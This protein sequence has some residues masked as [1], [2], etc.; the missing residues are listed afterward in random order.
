MEE[1]LILIVLT[2]WHHE[3]TVIPYQTI[4]AKLMK[5]A[6]TVGKESG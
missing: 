6:N 1:F 4:A 5:T 2:Y 3:P